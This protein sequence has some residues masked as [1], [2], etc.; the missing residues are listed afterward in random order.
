MYDEKK[1]KEL[2]AAIQI[3]RDWLYEKTKLYD[4]R[5]EGLIEGEAI[6]EAKGEEKAMKKA[7][8]ETINTFMELAKKRNI[9]IS[10]I[11][12]N[13]IKESTIDDINNLI[14][15]IFEIENEEDVIKILGK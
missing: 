12:M 15:N 11:T 3:E 9:S 1:F 5:V 4:A 6:G 8:V 13:K 2:L 10:E 7:L 14:K